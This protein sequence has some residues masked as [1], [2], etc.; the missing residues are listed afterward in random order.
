MRNFSSLLGN[1]NIFEGD[2]RETLDNLYGQM[3]RIH[4]DDAIL[5]HIASEQAA[6]LHGEMGWSDPGTLYALKEALADE[7]LQNVCEGRV[8]SRQSSDSLLVNKE[9]GKL[10]AVIGLEGM[11]V[12]NTDDAL[13][14]VHKDHI[15]LVKELVDSF[16]DTELEK[17]S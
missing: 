11:I 1:D 15:P 3:E 16:Q 8:V 12:V 17:Y 9:D 6:V 14:V 2:Y 7:T 4:F 5:T 10:L 13:L